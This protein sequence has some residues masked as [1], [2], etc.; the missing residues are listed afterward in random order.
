MGNDL[1]TCGHPFIQHT[2]FGETGRVNGPTSKTCCSAC[3][4][5]TPV[6]K[7]EYDARLSMPRPV[8]KPSQIKKTRGKKGGP[9]D[10]E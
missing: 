2:E 7:R 5:W 10:D 4:C 3:D 6:L 9:V 1:C 8:P